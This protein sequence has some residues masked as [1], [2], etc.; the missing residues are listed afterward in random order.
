MPAVEP[1]SNQCRQQYKPWYL[2]QTVEV[3]FSFCFFKCSPQAYFDVL[4]LAVEPP[5]LIFSLVVNSSNYI[6]HSNTFL[7]YVE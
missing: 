6:N 2:C 5:N 4:L 3:V 7:F 1:M